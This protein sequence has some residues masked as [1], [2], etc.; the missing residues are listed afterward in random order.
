[1]ASVVRFIRL[2]H[3]ARHFS[4]S[5]S[6]LLNRDQMSTPGVA[7]CHPLRFLVLGPDP[8]GDL[9]RWEEGT[10]ASS[11]RGRNRSCVHETLRVGVLRVLEDLAPRPISTI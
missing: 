4:A 8:T 6:L 3:H 2:G 10:F 5:S 11:I 1:M 7:Q 9:T